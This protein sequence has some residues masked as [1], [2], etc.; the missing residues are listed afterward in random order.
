MMFQRRSKSMLVEFAI[1]IGNTEVQTK[2]ILG[3]K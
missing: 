3:V 2:E 1:E